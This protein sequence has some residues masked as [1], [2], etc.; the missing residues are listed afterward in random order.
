MSQVLRRLKAEKERSQQQWVDYMVM[1]VFNMYF[2]FGKNS[3]FAD[4]GCVNVLKFI[5]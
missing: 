2:M 4:I 5:S 3:R 1:R